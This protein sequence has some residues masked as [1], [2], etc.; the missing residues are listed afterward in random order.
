MESFV[1]ESLSRVNPRFLSKEMERLL[2]SVM[3]KEYDISAEDEES[4][5]ISL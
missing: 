5:A 1:L 2:R 4:M 3:S